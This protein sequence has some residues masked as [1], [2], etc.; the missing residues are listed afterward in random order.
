MDIL[1]EIITLIAKLVLINVLLV[2]F[3]TQ[4]VKVA[5]E[6]TDYHGQLLIIYASR[7][8]YLNKK[9][10]DVCKDIL[11]KSIKVNAKLVLINVVLVLILVV[12]V[13]VA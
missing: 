3:L 9:F 2:L 12:I 7:I 13:L 1:I 5:V 10:L 4:I 6:Y 8:L 11:I